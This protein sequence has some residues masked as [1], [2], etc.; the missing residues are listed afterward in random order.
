[1]A[2]FQF[3]VEFGGGPSLFP[4]SQSTAHIM[5]TTARVVPGKER[6]LRR[7]VLGE[8]LGV[9]RTEY[10]TS[11]YLHGRCR[12]QKTKETRLGAV[13]AG[14]VRATRSEDTYSKTSAPCLARGTQIVHDAP[15]CRQWDRDGQRHDGSRAMSIT[16]E[17][18]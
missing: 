1:M 16:E 6:L 2:C 17:D 10:M 7:G 3:D 4:I 11:T 12:P 15:V 9:Q 14:W 5:A 13:P 8:A 18:V